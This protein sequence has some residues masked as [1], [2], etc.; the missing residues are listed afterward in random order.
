[1]VAAAFKE[2]GFARGDGEAVFHLHHS[3]DAVRV[4]QMM[5]SSTRCAASE[6]AEIRRS[7]E[8]VEW[9]TIS[10][11]TAPDMAPGPEVSA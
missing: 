3:G 2:V 9:F 7:G 1:M 10:R 8:V 6:E 5:W 4:D 11:K